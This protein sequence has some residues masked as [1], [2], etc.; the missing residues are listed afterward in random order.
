MIEKEPDYV[1]KIAAVGDYCVGTT[2][3]ITYFIQRKFHYNTHPTFGVN[4][5]LKEMV[6]HDKQGKNILCN[7]LLWDLSGRASYAT[8]RKLYYKG[9][10]A[11]LLVYD[12]TRMDTFDSIE[13]VWSKEY[14]ENTTGEHIFAIAGNK[15]DLVDIR[16]V[17]AVNG[18]DL[19]QKIGA[20]QFLETSAK[21]GTNVVEAF[22]NLVNVLLKK[23]GEN[24]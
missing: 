24:V 14:K 11:A 17:P 5:I 6:I 2:S 18:E 7:I 21:D 10:S 1:F 9:C 15:A 22:M 20:T 16:K 3:L 4:L 13:A 19:R 8:V 23:S 12:I